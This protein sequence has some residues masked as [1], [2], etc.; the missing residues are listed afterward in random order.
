MYSDEKK[1]DVTYKGISSYL[2]AVGLTDSIVRGWEFR[3]RTGVTE[4][5]DGI[6]NE[7]IEKEIDKELEERRQA[8]KSE[9]ATWEAKAR[10]AQWAGV[11]A[12]TD[13]AD[14]ADKQPRDFTSFLP[15][16][17]VSPEILKF[18]HGIIDSGFR[19][20]ATKHHPDHN[21][22][23]EQMQDLNAAKKLLLQLLQNWETN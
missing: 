5:L 2:K 21:G 16:T 13:T 18:A 17:K 22:N 19:S 9:F 3:L 15:P 20:L 4:F 23:A 1:K 11:G 14:T 10:A 6:E 12:T 8:R 7:R